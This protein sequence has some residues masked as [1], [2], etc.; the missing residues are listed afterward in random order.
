MYLNQ[1]SRRRFLGSTVQFASGSFRVMRHFF[2][3]LCA[4]SG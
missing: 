1:I 4:Q 2:V 3:A